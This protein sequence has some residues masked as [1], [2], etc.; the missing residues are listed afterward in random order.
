M[1]VGRMLGW[2][3]LFCALVL[4]GWDAVSSLDSVAK[5]DD[6]R[7]SA[8]WAELLGEN[9]A[10]DPYRCQPPVATVL[11]PPE[12]ARLPRRVRGRLPHYGFFH[13]D[14]EGTL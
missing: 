7:A 8:H 1:I 2:L 9:L 12:G 6:P 13:G 4:L 3:L 5:L 11:G 10:R 14:I